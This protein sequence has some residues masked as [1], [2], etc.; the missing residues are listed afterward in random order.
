MAEFAQKWHVK[1]SKF[2]LFKNR[3][4]SSDFD[5]VL[6][7]S[8]ASTQTFFKKNRAAEKNCASTKK[9]RDARTIERTTWQK[10]CGARRNRI[11][12]EDTK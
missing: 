2:E 3:E 8:I 5:D 9:N 1:F 11:A 7:E 10:F 6:T 4:Y 12:I